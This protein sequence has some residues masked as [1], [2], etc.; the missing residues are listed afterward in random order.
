MERDIVFGE[1]YV[2]RNIGAPIARDEKIDCPAKSHN[3]IMIAEF[4]VGC[5]SLSLLSIWHETIKFFANHF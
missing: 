2:F 4:H 5:T 3:E 1:F